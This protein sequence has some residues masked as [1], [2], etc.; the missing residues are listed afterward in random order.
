MPKEEPVK[1]TEL[2]EIQIQTNNTQNQVN[3]QIVR[4]GLRII[5]QTI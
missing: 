2:E 3:I 4:M 5:T 1:R